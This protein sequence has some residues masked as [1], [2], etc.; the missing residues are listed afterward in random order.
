MKK[1]FLFFS[2]P[3]IFSCVSG[4]K[5]DSKLK[6]LNGDSYQR[7]TLILGVPHLKTKP[8]SKEKA[9]ETWKASVAK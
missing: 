6:Y 3:F 9:K 5:L 1:Y 4:P 2:V 8:E 7:K